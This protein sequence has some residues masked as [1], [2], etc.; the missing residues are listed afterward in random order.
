MKVNG[1]RNGKGKEY[2]DDKVV[3]E[4]EFLKGKRWNGKAKG[5]DRWKGKKIFEIDY[6]KGKKWNGKIFD[7]KN[8]IICEIINDNG[9]FKEYDK[10]NYIS[11]EGEYKNGERNGKG[12][13]YKS[14]YLIFEGEYLND[15]RNGKG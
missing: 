5:Y 10:V 13:E 15:E 12:K 4:G 3:F 8:N 1:E 9:I 2:V 11:F 6:I 7:E 14:G